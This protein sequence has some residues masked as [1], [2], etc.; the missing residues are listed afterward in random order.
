MKKIRLRT[1]SIDDNNRTMTNKSYIA[2]W[3]FLLSA[4]FNPNRTHA[5]E[6]GLGVILFEP[7]GLSV[8]YFIDRDTSIDAAIGWGVGTRYS[9]FY[10]HSTYLWHLPKQIDLKKFSFDVFYGLGGRLISWEDHYHPRRSY[11]H[12][13]STITDIGVR[14]AGGLG[15]TFADPGLEIFSEI[16]LTMNIIRDTYADIDLGLGVRYYF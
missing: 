3:L 2:F 16:S 14:G 6:L 10:L 15:Y 11:R 12:S 7:S 13:D 9:R 1:N 5:N 8:N 4:F